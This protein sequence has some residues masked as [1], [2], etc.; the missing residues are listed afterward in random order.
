MCAGDKVVKVC[1]MTDGVAET[2]VESRR[3][4]FV[5]LLWKRLNEKKNICE[6]NNMI[7]RLLEDWNPVNAGDD[8]TLVSYEK[9]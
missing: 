3:N 8:R 7:Y 6:R 5:N 2:L 4:E 9:R 1:L